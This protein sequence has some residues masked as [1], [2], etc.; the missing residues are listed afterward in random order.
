[1]GAA[2]LDDLVDVRQGPEQ[3]W[4]TL[5]RGVAVLAAGEA[6]VEILVEERPA[7]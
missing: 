7:P 3:P 4:A 6:A 5:I 1:M 2:Q